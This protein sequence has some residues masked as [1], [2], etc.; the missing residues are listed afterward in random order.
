MALP[1]RDLSFRNDVVLTLAG[2]K[3][4]GTPNSFSDWFSTGINRY[5]LDPN[6]VPGSNPTDRLNEVGDEPY[7]LGHFRNY[8]HNINLDGDD[9]RVIGFSTNNLN[10][11][12][13]G[14]I[15]FQEDL[16]RG[17]QTTATIT[18]DEAIGL[19]SGVF[20]GP[21]DE[22]RINVSNIQIAVWDGSDWGSFG[23]PDTVEYRIDAGS[24]TSGAITIELTTA[25][26]ISFRFTPGR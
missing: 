1:F 2:L 14:D 3:E 13:D 9:V 25:E 21:V 6:Y 20:E 10:D 18:V 16:G 19:F 17:F 24:W 26:I 7:E 4:P 12:L 8:E 23:P 15:L 22:Y 11:K 5:G